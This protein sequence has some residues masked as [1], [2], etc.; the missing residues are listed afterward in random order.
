MVVREFITL[1]GFKVEDEKLQKYEKGIAKVK[2]GIAIAG[3]A[4]I[5]LG[6]VFL[7]T[8]GDMEQTQ[9]AFDT[10]LGSTQKANKLLAQIAKFAATTPFERTELINYAKS[11]LGVGWAAD[12]IIP[13]L[14]MLGNIAAGIGKE[15]LP[16]IMLA[17][18]K[19]KSKGRASLEELW[20]MVEAGVPI[21]DQLS[22]DLGMTK[23]QIIKMAT[24]GKL[25][26][27]QVQK[28]LKEVE[29]TK[30]AGLMVKQSK[31]FLG[32]VSNIVDYLTILAG[33]IGADLLP[34]IKDLAIEF[35]N[36]MEANKDIIKGGIVKFFK[37][38]MWVIGYVVVAVEGLIKDL[39]GL[40]TITKVVGAIFY[41]VSNIIEGL[42]IGLWPFR[43]ILLALAITIG[44]I[45]AAQWAWN[46]AL[47]ANP[48][49]LIIIAV[50]LLIGVAVTLM[51]NWD[52][53]K[54]F[55]VKMWDSIVSAFKQAWSYIWSLLD[56]KWIQALLA[57]FAPFI[58][59]PIA[60]IKNWDVISKFFT[61][62][63]RGIVDTFFWA[64]NKI[65]SV[66][67]WLVGAFDKVAQFLGFK[68]P[69]KKGKGNSGGEDGDTPPG[70]P[71]DPKQGAP[72]TV[73]HYAKG[74]DYVPENQ[75]A[76]LHK[77]ER[78]LPAGTFRGSGKPTVIYQ[79]NSTPKIQV[80]PGT[81]NSQVQYLEAAAKKIFREEWQSI[82]R[83]TK[84]SFSLPETT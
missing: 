72:A 54:K 52:K 40:S 75:L 18:N 39:G 13:T 21:L 51:K 16:N 80:P 48:I 25:S 74:T 65:S 17:F 14:N 66:W 71:R 4:V 69:N 26:F 10:I 20:P 34:M 37:S 33:D 9:I 38:L 60:I 28:S 45:T 55:F 81:P 5:G 63:W 76:Y 1:L 15:K 2:T 57:M 24:D 22:K 82:L 46:V 32:I 29:Q 73:P 56:N 43:R 44:I 78:I 79:I 3:A 42:I 27:E 30:F 68:S 41:F 19:M 58:G 8:A 67:G 83:Q 53:V 84:G 6:T 31:S 62:L 49:G 77:G 50:L 64:V 23:D 36:F 59:I 61:D 7:K 47:A 35:L 12:D 70:K 11:M